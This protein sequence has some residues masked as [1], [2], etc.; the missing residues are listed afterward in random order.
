MAILLNCYLVIQTPLN[1]SEKISRKEITN[2]IIIEKVVKQDEQLELKHIR[3]I[4]QP[5][6][7]NGESSSRNQVVQQNKINIFDTMM[8]RA[9][10][11]YF[12]MQKREDIRCD[13]LYNDVITLL[14][15]KQKNGWSGVNSE[16]FANKF[17]ERLVALL[18]YI[19]PH[20]EKLIARLLK[21]PDIFNELE[22]YQHNESYNKFYF[23]GHHKKEQ[24]S[25]KKLEKL[26]KSLEL[27]IEQPWA[28]DD[29][30]IDF[31]IQVLLL[32]KN[33]NKYIIYLQEINQKMNTIHN[34]N[35]STHNPG[36]DLMVYT[37]EASDSI[38]SKYEELSDFLFEKDSYKFFDLDEYTSH[39]VIQKYNYIKN[40]QLNVPVTIYRYYQGNYLRTINYIWKVP[41]RNDH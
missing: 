16:S 8:E 9:R 10:Q 2:S 30:W 18:W 29:K 6:E 22:Q 7:D 13:I 23:T 34:S 12:S 41:L 4:I 33:I 24:L 11:P 27:S 17:V 5:E 36:C 14:R 15:N 19:D 31:I 37:I 35:V 1:D 40:L 32:I 28:N 20:R 39:N 38:H 3:F 21:L 25:H 26:V